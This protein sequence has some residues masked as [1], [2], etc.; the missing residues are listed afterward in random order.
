MTT[1]LRMFMYTMAGLMI[2][3]PPKKKSYKEMN[4]E[5]L[6]E[7]T[8]FQKRTYR[9]PDKEIFQQ[10]FPSLFKDILILSDT[11]RKELFYKTLGSYVHKAIEI[12]R[13]FVVIEAITPTEEKNFLGLLGIDQEVRKKFVA[14]SSHG[15]DYFLREKAWQEFPKP[16]EEPEPVPEVDLAEKPLA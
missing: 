7:L 15:L 5:F 10:K 8:K 6:E 11:S 1:T 9:V 2:P 4:Q 12:T 3:E 16:K 14:N 13:T